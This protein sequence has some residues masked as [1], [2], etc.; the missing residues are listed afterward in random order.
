MKKE[1]IVNQLIYSV[2][3]SGLVAT[4]YEVFGE[5]VKVGIPFSHQ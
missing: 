3:Q 4:L 5:S 1:E 2:C